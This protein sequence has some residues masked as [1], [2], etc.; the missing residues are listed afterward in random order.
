MTDRISIHAIDTLRGGTIG[1]RNTVESQRT[2]E[3]VDEVHLHYLAK[4]VE[5]VKSI[6]ESSQLLRPH[7]LP[8]YAVTMRLLLLDIMTVGSFVAAISSAAPFTK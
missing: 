8:G 2:F 7:F 1:P 3:R 5:I 4:L 6:I